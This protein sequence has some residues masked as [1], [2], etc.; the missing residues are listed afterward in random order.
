MRV[1]PEEILLYYDPAMSISKKTLAYAKTISTNVNM[2]EYHKEHFTPTVWRQILK[3]LDLEPKQIVN[4]ATPYYQNNLKG[5]QFE[6]DDW[7]NI[8][9][10][11]PDLIR[12]PIA[13]KGDYTVLVDNP[14]DIYRLK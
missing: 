6:M 13:I 9:T 5:R 12:T 4:K 7:I 1:H 14:T 2:V 10:H 8:L 11:Q 3:M